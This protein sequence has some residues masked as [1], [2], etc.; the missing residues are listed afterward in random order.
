MQRGGGRKEGVL[1]GALEKLSEEAEKILVFIRQAED[2]V[3]R[4]VPAI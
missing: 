4:V 1:A 2:D 3:R